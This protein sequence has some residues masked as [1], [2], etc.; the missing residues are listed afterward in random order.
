MEV[1]DLEKSIRLLNK[2]WNE[3]FHIDKI[4]DDQIVSFKQNHSTD[5]IKI[6][7]KME[8]DEKTNDIGLENLN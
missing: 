5:K 1:V 6:K 2:Q 3:L 4:K 7:F 8:Y